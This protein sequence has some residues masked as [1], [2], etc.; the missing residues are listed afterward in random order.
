V[1]AL[2]AIGEIWLLTDAGASPDI[3]THARSLA[4]SLRRQGRAARVLALAD[5]GRLSPSASASI[6][7]EILPGGFFGLLKA[8]RSERPWLL[9]THGCKAGVLG[10]IAARLSGTPVVSTFHPHEA[11][12]V[13]ARAWEALERMTAPLG[14]CLTHERTI[15]E[16]LGERAALLSPFVAPAVPAAIKRDLSGANFAFVGRLSYE[17]GPDL[18]CAL[19]EHLPCGRFTVY[20]DGPMRAELRARYEGPVKFRGLPADRARLWREMDLLCVTARREGLP[21]AVLEAMAHGV[22]VAAFAAGE[23]AGVVERG[24]FLAAP[25]DSAGLENRLRAW[26]ISSIEE[27]RARSAAAR[28]Y[29]ETHYSAAAA[30]PSILSAYRR[31]RA[32]I[33][34]GEPVRNG[35]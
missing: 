8:L 5:T 3:Q 10:R 1:N 26:G 21:M 14:E 24:G 35:A 4:E 13:C 6:P 29:V 11:E 12:A 20:G 30:L 32:R 22:P 15:A 2:N 25:G 33:K 7:P 34:P 28:R 23:L 9:H 19:A 31:A 27:R 17:A 16:R 18:F